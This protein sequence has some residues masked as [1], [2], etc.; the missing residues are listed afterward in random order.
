[1]FLNV[2]G[3]ISHIFGTK[4]DILSVPWYTILTIGLEKRVSLEKLETYLKLY[5]FSVFNF[6]TLSIMGGDNPL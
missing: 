5:G 2:C 3:N 6:N 4:Y 1:M